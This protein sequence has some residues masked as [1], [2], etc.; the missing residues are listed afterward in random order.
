LDPEEVPVELRELPQWVCWRYVLRDRSWTKVPFDARTGRPAS[1][2]DPAS[3]ASFKVALAAQGEYDGV[4]FVLAADGPY[5]GIDLDRC[6]DESGEVTVPAQSI[7]ESFSSYAEVSPS[8]RGV[9]L[10]TRAVKPTQ[11]CRSHALEGMKEI[12]IYAGG[13]FFTIT[14]RRLPGAP[15]AVTDGQ[16]ALSALCERLWPQEAES[17]LPSSVA[18]V[19]ELGD[20]ELLQHAFAARNGA[21]FTRLW[22]GDTRDYDGDDS[23]ADLALCSML[24]YW[25]GR[26]SIRVD[27]L[28]RQSGLYR[29]EKWGRDDYRDATISKAIASCKKVYNPAAVTAPRRSSGPGLPE[30]F[31]GTDEHRVIDEAVAAVSRDSEVFQRGARLVRIVRAATQK[32]PVARPEGSGTI[33]EIPTASLREC[34]TRSAALLKYSPKGDIVD[35]HPPEWLVSGVAARARWPGV[36][37]LV[38]LADAPLLR[39]DGSIL[40]SAG[41]DPETA[42]VLHLA[43]E[44]PVVPERATLDDAVAARDKL[45]E[46]T[47]DFRFEHQSHRATYVAAIL[48]RLARFAF[49][50][51]CPLFLV[52]ANVRGAGKGLLVQTISRITLGRDMPVSSYCHDTEEMRKK[53][54]A[55]AIAGDSLVLLDNLEG[56]FGNDA[57]DRALTCMTWRDRILG[58]S[59]QVELPLL[60]IWFAT[61]NNVI[62]GADTARR[63]IP[64]RLDVLEEKPENR[65][66]FKYPDLLGW[67][68]RERGSLLAAGLTILSAFMRA[69]CPSQSLPPMGSFE[70]WSGLVRQA[71]VWAGMDDPCASRASMCEA[72]DAVADSLRML[73][74]A[75]KSYAPPPQQI[76][77]T[78]LLADLYPTQRE[79]APQ[80][81]AAI[82]MR[83]ALETLTGTPPG[84]APDAR[85]VGNRLKSFRRRVVDGLCIDLAPAE[86]NRAGATWR[87]FTAAEAQRGATLRVSESAS[88]RSGERNC[89]DDDG[90]VA[91]IPV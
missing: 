39:P 4:G 73:I 30:I 87:L 49:Q 27:A 56:S 84:R 52:D 58:S 11:R 24:A 59:E 76:V 48:S 66:D 29:A 53:I 86:R 25:T 43:G 32:G 1:S 40:Q 65:S 63:I 78:N 81:L 5:V 35:A 85:R 80:T 8:G 26:D 42:V 37:E 6:I 64:M 88:P 44:F 60:P 14:G 54:T 3:W 33:A 10:I 57:L 91:G 79:H 46:V 22:E 61:G 23:R 74:D 16:P 69:G 51:P 71:V 75:W 7:I 50:G 68:S 38:G 70:G 20:E 18:A 47:C 13:R 21:K 15:G 36:R 77:V 72:S 90:C 12:E 28:F 2:T 45:L 34:I 82:A 17:P 83:G 31:I 9:K 89:D 67:V 62:V 41:Y 19:T 55:I